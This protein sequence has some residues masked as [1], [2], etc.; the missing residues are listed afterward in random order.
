MFNRLRPSGYLH[1]LSCL[2]QS[3]TIASGTLMARPGGSQVKIICGHCAVL[4]RL[5]WQLADLIGD[6]DIERSRP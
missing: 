3:P 6:Q 4:E 1:R 2:L 5:P